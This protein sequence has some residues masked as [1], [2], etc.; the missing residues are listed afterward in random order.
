MFEKR[1]LPG[2][3][4]ETTQAPQSHR[5]AHDGVRRVRRRRRLRLALLVGIVALIATTVTPVSTSAARGV[6]SPTERRASADHSTE[7]RAD[8][9]GPKDHGR[10]KDKKSI[11]VRI[12]LGQT[13]SMTA[14]PEPLEAGAGTAAGRARQRGQQGES[15]ALVASPANAEVTHQPGAAA[16]TPDVHGTYIFERKPGKAQGAGATRTLVLEVEPAEQLVCVNTRVR[17]AG[18]PD[19]GVPGMKVGDTEFLRTSTDPA[20]LQV[21]VLDRATAGQPHDRTPVNSTFPATAGGYGDYAAFLSNSKLDNSHLVLVSGFVSPSTKAQVWAPLGRLGAVD[22]AVPQQGFEFSFIG[23]PG[24]SKGS[25]WQAA[26]PFAA[27][28]PTTCDTDMAGDPRT[29]LSGWLTRDTTGERYAYVSADFV[30]FDTEP[31]AP[32]GVHAIKVGNRTYT[33]PTGQWN[34]FHAL[35][36]DRRTLCSE[37]RATTECDPGPPLLNQGFGPDSGG[38]DAMNVALKPWSTNPD[39]LLI[40]APFA[41]TDGARSGVVPSIDL[42]TTLRAFG[43][44]PLAPGRSLGTGVKYALVGG[45]CLSTSRSDTN[46]CLNVGLPEGSA[47]PIVAESFTGFGQPGHI[48]G[49]LVRDRQNRFHPREASLAGKQLLALG[50]IVYGPTSPWPEEGDPDLEAAFAYLSGKL[51]FPVDEQHPHGV[52]EQYLVWNTEASVPDPNTRLPSTLCTDLPATVDPTACATVLAELRTEFLEVKYID[53]FLELLKTAY[54]EVEGEHANEEIIKVVTDDITALLTPPQAESSLAL[55]IVHL[56]LSI[57]SLIP[58]VGEAFAL[59]GE[60]LDFAE[61][62]LADDKGSSADP[63]QAVYDTGDKLLEATNDAFGQAVAQIDAYQP[64]IVSDY[65]KLH[66]VGQRANTDVPDAPWAFTNTDLA[67][68]RTGIEAAL[69]QWLYPALVDAGFPVWWIKIPSSDINFGDLVPF[70]DTDRTPNIYRCR[71]SETG[72]DTHPFDAEPADGWIKLGNGHSDDNRFPFVWYDFYLALGGTRFAPHELRDHSHHAP[73]PSAT[74]LAEM[75]GSL[76]DG[77]VGIDRTWYFEHMFKRM[78]DD[79][80]TLVLDCTD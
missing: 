31:S 66:L 76:G 73:V 53:H 41:G 20:G 50:E 61:S 32:S 49:T 18:S 65:A 16:F 68:A 46:P 11:T 25:A 58:E 38:L 6:Q 37:E 26:D 62:L 70:N 72:V 69:K 27:A 8:G 51:G 60:V 22:I 7:N 44:S 1:T 23:A 4:G 67:Q 29:N 12:R 35:V 5:R 63:M 48:A 59:A 2:A 74:L 45:G 79:G 75:F 40:V 15:W 71:N 34:G 56:V 13:V 9:R 24:M 77:D 17:P 78:L 19:P 10:G 55:P 30:D 57:A 80:G 33:V 36:L 28:R 54:I 64:L 39:V 47:K 21:V 52:R 42:I 43:A 3:R 14:T